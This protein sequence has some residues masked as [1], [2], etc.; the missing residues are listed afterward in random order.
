[1]FPVRIGIGMAVTTGIDLLAL[2]C[3]L[4]EI[5][6]QVVNNNVFPGFKNNMMLFF[7]IGIIYPFIFYVFYYLVTYK[8]LR[9]AYTRSI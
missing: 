2:W 6:N 4:V 7:R 9:H 1:M 8:L 5:R 3:Q